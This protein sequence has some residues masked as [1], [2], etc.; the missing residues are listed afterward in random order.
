M[1]L[2]IQKN[3]SQLIKNQFPEFYKSE[4]ELFLAFVQAYYEWME[5]QQFDVTNDDG[6]VV[7]QITNDGVIHHSRNLPDYRDID[8]TLDDFILSFKNK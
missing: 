1:A 5:T 8:R 7:G 4:G 2:D 3:I 6:D